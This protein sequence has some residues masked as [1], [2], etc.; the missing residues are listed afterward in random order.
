[1]AEQTEPGNGPIPF[2]QRLLDN[3]FLLLILGLVVMG[4]FYTGWGLL[5]IVLLPKNPL[6]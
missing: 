3:P 1:M 6:P 4:V 2:G 5:E